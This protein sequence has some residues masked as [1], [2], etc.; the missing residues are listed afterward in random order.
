[1]IGSLT[2]IGTL[3]AVVAL[4]FLAGMCLAMAVGRE[5]GDF[6]GFYR[7]KFTSNANQELAEMFIFMDASQLFMI[8]IAALVLIPIGVHA[9]F[10]LWV[11]TAGVFVVLLIVPGAIWAR[12]RKKRLN[13]FEEQ[14]PDVFM[15][16]TSS[17]QAGA[18]MNMALA[19]VV[20]QTPAPASQELGLLVK[21][22]QLGVTL[23]DSLIEL[24]R[25][26]P[27]QSF[28]MASSAIR[29]SR[30]VGGNL[31][32]TI[33]SMAETL[34]RKKTMEGKIDSLTAQGRAQGTFMAMLP[35]AL[36]VLLSFLEPEAMRKLY[37]TREGLMVLAVMVFMQIMGFTFIRKI[38]SIDS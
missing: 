20:K 11:I 15:M 24:E 5:A 22:M 2:D 6:M 7:R 3:A 29:I 36:A 25:R 27:L 12:M 8:N 33:Q 13:K 17:L 26:I 23:E 10:Q 28:V 31:V 35:I 9:L 4:V 14:L 1:M 30:E 34:R 21:R 37:T 32:E 19:D 18:S 38:T 16:L